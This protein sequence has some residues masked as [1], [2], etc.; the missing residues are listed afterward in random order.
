MSDGVNKATND[1]ASGNW[2]LD[3]RV[4]VAIIVAIGLQTFGAVW[5]AATTSA[6]TES[7]AIEIARLNVLMT[8]NDIK[9]QSQRDSV[10][11]VT[12][13]VKMMSST[14]DRQTQILDKLS[15]QVARIPGVQ[16]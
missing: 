3:K 5:W 8:A 2:H 4:P 14:I 9:T 13:Q 12:T 1:P 7:N 15:N 16:Q 6:R 10:I 11:E